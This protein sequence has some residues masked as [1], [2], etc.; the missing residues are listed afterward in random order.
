MMDEKVKDMAVE[1]KDWRHTDRIV[2]ALAGFIGGLVLVLMVATAVFFMV[3]VG[4]MEEGNRA[5][6]CAVPWLGCT[7]GYICTINGPGGPP[8]GGKY[9]EEKTEKE[10]ETG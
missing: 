3:V 1:R 10:K 9:W 8:R 5:L 7:A 2:V 4:W 6:R